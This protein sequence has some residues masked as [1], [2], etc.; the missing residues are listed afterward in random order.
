MSAVSSSTSK[1]Q[2]QSLLGTP[3]P[4]AKNRKKKPTKASPAPKVQAAATASFDLIKKIITFIQ[5][6]SRTSS[7]KESMFTKVEPLELSVN[8]QFECMKTLAKIHT[9]ISKLL[10]EFQSALSRRDNGFLKSRK[11]EL[12]DAMKVVENL[13]N[14]A[15]EVLHK[16]IYLDPQVAT[17]D[18]HC[19]LVTQFIAL[20]QQ[21]TSIIKQLKNKG[22]TI[23]FPTPTGEAAPTPTTSDTSDKVCKFLKDHPFTSLGVSASLAYYC[24][25][26][27]YESFLWPV[28]GGGADYLID[29]SKNLVKDAKEIS[30]S[31]IN[32]VGSAALPIAATVAGTSF[33]YGEQNWIR[34]IITIGAMT[35]LGF[36]L[37]NN[38]NQIKNQTKDIP[39]S[40]S[41][42]WFKNGEKTGLVAGAASILYGMSKGGASGLVSPSYHLWNLMTGAAIFGFHAGAA[43]AV[44]SANK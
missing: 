43:K 16:Y 7:P 2:Q 31:L 27:D 26:G 42:T 22:I 44:K 20:D 39:K 40:L 38:R 1:A 18:Q 3:Q 19:L 5:G 6:P 15:Q 29:R 23:L 24:T 12:R 33:F 35:N 17:E 41:I 37:Y 36:L 32:D 4:K 14:Q 21:Q 34:T 11:S 28:L 13:R 10:A 25:G 8:T 9:E 30:Y